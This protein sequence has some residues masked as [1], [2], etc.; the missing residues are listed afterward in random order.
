MANLITM[1]HSVC[2]HQAPYSNTACHTTWHCLVSTIVPYKNIS[3]V[4]SIVNTNTCTTS[5]S[6]TKI[7]LK[8]LKDTPTCFGHSTIIREFLSS[9]MKSLLLTTLWI[10]L[11]KK[12]AMWQHV[13]LCVLSYTWRSPVS[14]HRQALSKYNSTHITRHA[15]TSPA[16][17]IGISKVLLIKVILARN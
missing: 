12:L 7:Y 4:H 1:D 15:A 13:V 6:L 9:S 11:Y 14:V 16:F 17:N 2:K 8:F 3:C 10:F 5:M